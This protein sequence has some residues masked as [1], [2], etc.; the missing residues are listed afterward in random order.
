MGRS[1]EN[2]GLAPDLSR[3]PG[4]V[5]DL[6]YHG[7]RREHLSRSEAALEVCAAMFRASYGLDEL[8]MV[9]TDPTNAISESFFSK[10]ATQAE[11]WLER[12]VPAAYD[13]VN[14]SERDDE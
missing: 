9:L 3:L 5:R 11:A 14:R 12:I 2:L 6:I 1:L 7:N 8:W 4:A 13:A 10:D